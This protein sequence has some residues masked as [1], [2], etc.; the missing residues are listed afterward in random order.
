MPG[1]SMMV[2]GAAA[3]KFPAYVSRPDLVVAAMAAF[4]VI[5]LAGLWA[6][7]RNARLF[8]YAA[9]LNIAFLFFVFLAFDP[10]ADD[11]VASRSAGEY[12]RLE[13]SSA[14]GVLCSKMAVRGVRYYS[15]KDVGVLKLGGGAFFS[16][17]PIPFID[18]ADELAGYLKD[19]HNVVAVLERKDLAAAREALKG[20]YD[21]VLLKE[22]GG[23]SVVKFTIIR[24]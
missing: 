5:I 13:Q 11:V 12:V 6:V 22:F 23:S 17:H 18:S 9:A 1:E 7:L 24:K 4:L 14:D 20:R 15:G 21:C 2:I 3:F 19:R 8:P 16:A 10:Y